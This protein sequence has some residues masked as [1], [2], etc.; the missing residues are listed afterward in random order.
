MQS[1][2]QQQQDQ[3][4]DCQ[5]DSLQNL[6]TNTSSAAN[7][8]LKGQTIPDTP[9]EYAEFQH[10]IAPQE[11]P[12]QLTLEE[13]GLTTQEP[14]EIQESSDQVSVKGSLDDKL[15][16]EQI[17]DSQ[18]NQPQVQ[19]DPRL[20]FENPDNNFIPDPSQIY[21]QL[22]L[23]L[24]SLP[25]ISNPLSQ[26]PFRNSTN[27]NTVFPNMTP[28]DEMQANNGVSDQQENGTLW[29]T[30]QQH[31]Q[32]NNH[33]LA[34]GFIQDIVKRP[35]MLSYKWFV[36]K[37]YNQVDAVK[38]IVEEWLSN[39]NQNQAMYIEEIEKANQLL[40]ETLW[41]MRRPETE[42]FI[43]LLTKESSRI[44]NKQYFNRKRE[45]FHNGQAY[46]QSAQSVERF[47][48]N[49]NP[50]LS[51]QNKLD[52]TTSNQQNV[53]APSE[54]QSQ[55][56]LQ[57]SHLN[58]QKPSLEVNQ[59][60]D[61]PTDSKFQSPKKKEDNQDQPIQISDQ[62]ESP[63]DKFYD[64]FSTSCQI[65]Q[66]PSIEPRDQLHQSYQ[67]SRRFSN[68]KPA[69]SRSAVRP[70]RRFDLDSVSRPAEEN[71]FQI[72]LQN[73]RTDNS[74]LNPHRFNRVSST[75][76]LI[77]NKERGYQRFQHPRA[78]FFANQS[79]QQY[80]DYRD[81][82]LRNFRES[83]PLSNQNN[84][85]PLQRE[86]K[87]QALQ[88]YTLEYE[89]PGMYTKPSRG[90]QNPNHSYN[91]SNYFKT[92]MNEFYPLPYAVSKFQGFQRMTHPSNYQ[93]Q[94]E[95]AH[96]QY[97][98][99]QPNVWRFSAGSNYYNNKF[100]GNYNRHDPQYLPQ[101]NFMPQQHYTWQHPRSAMH[102]NTGFD[103]QQQRQPYSQAYGGY[104]SNT[105]PT[106]GGYQPRRYQQWQYGTNAAPHQAYQNDSRNI[107]YMNQTYVR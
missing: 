42:P 66:Q 14:A 70:S 101:K 85:N 107:N 32:I 71:T 38:E 34:S 78:Q 2:V 28:N 15:Q 68:R 45:E 73:Q 102:Y 106:N 94:H 31:I 1:Q 84:Y 72:N 9:Q 58:S 76:R 52:T 88:N 91:Q 23:L 86:T 61:Q 11:T 29:D 47:P 53:A 56:Q 4:S 8:Q 80:G 65:R 81:R 92:R 77:E 63:S 103:Y 46:F 69:Y 37:I 6:A 43:K 83:L 74:D 49:H 39:M 26:Q 33:D 10:T 100:D 97:Q 13:E 48:Q 3:L 90:F 67:D 93:E 57:N 87:Y 50:L 12:T 54:L 51:S 95:L 18:Q 99:R 36:Q 22:K 41:E 44:E 98:Q 62:K 105:Y 19:F 96:T 59:N 21:E 27:F 89:D 60:V 82:Q 16:Q 55:T 17:E 30:I 35:Q 75:S 24:Q 5:T 20:I 79:Y 7:V 104:D 25:D 40:R 64:K